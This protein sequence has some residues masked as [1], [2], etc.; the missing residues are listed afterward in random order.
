MN[1]S[2]KL[3]IVLIFLGAVSRLMHLPP[4]IAAVTGVAIFAGYAISN[5]WL[6]LLVP[7]LAMVLA[8][9]FL[10]LYPSIVFTY[11]GMIAGVFIARA[12]LKPLT[13]VRLIATTFLASFAFFVISN[14][15][16]WAEGYYGYTLEGLVACYIAAIPFWQNSLIA[17]FTS[18]ALIFGLYLLARRAFPA[19]GAKA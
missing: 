12:L 13:P 8:D 4:N 16:T 3:A 9:V 6:A 5:R 14:F 7:V 2:E 11:A 10:G 17:D 15:G 19:L 1:N 18:T